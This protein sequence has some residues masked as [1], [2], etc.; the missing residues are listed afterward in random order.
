MQQSD[1]RCASF[2]PLSKTMLLSADLSL[3]FV[4]HLKCLWRESQPSLALN[5]LNNTKL[6]QCLKLL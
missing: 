6:T 2:I 4:S 1:F 5:R 3:V